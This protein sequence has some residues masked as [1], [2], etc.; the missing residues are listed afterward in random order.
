MSQVP[1]HCLWHP[2]GPLL[3]KDKTMAQQTHSLPATS[4]EADRRLKN[5][6]LFYWEAPFSFF[7]FGCWQQSEIKK[8]PFALVAETEHILWMDKILHHQKTTGTMIS[9]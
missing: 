6:I 1:A 3:K 8:A 4:M 7:H 2:L 5:K 9:L